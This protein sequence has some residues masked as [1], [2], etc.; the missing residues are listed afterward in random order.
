MLKLVLTQQGDS[1]HGTYQFLFD[2][3]GARAPDDVVGT[4]EN[5]KQQLTDRRDRFWLAPLGVAT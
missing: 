4:F 5:G 2:G 3:A 1:G